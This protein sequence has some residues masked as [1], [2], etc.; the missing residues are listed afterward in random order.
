MEVNCPTSK[1]LGKNVGWTPSVQQSSNWNFV[2][3]MLDTRSEQRSSR[4]TELNLF[5]ARNCPVSNV[6]HPYRRLDIGRLHANHTKPLAIAL[7]RPQ[8]AKIRKSG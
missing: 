1:V 8:T 4:R 7:Q 2:E 3:Q 5:G 6:Q